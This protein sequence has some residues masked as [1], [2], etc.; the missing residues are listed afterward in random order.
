MAYNPGDSLCGCTL[1]RKCGTGAYGE[2]WLAE[3]PVGARVALKII[4]GGAVSERELNGLRNYKDCNHPNLLRIRHVEIADGEIRYTMDAADDLNRGVGEYKPDTLANR[5][6]KYGRM[7]GKEAAA[8]L[9]GLLAGLEELHRR[10]LVHRDIKPDNILWVNGRPTLADVGLV[11]ADGKGSLVGTP[12]FMSPKLMSGKGPADASDDFYAL[13]KVLYCALTGLPVGEYP[14]I[15]ASMTISADAALGR[16]YR[17][18]CRQ[19]VRSSAEF[20]KLLAGSAPAKMEKSA[21][22]P[23]RRWLVPCLFVL[24]VVPGLFGLRGGPAVQRA[25]EKAQAAELVAK[26]NEAKANLDKAQS[27]MKAEVEKFESGDADLRKEMQSRTVKLFLRVDLLPGDG[28]LAELLPDYET[29]AKQEILSLLMNGNRTPRLRPTAGVQARTVRT[30][31][32]LEHRLCGMF[33]A[34]YPD[35][36]RAKV[37]AR[38]TFWRN[39]PGTPA[40][41]QQKMLETD[42]VMQAVALDAMIRYKVNTILER[43]EFRSGEKRELG[44]LFELRQGLVEPIAGASFP[45]HLFAE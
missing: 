12:G 39:E 20:R 26:L 7:D 40:Q 10:G 29:M 43:G 14:S 3:D 8:M 1:L 2:V 42:P 21:R 28:K 13:G 37:K 45:S 34:A 25:G 19:P 11:A 44:E 17:E 35:F 30:P 36:D 27:D 22:I 38:Q 31:S 4:R 41:I 15:P 23:W 5:L 24:L 33:M 32:P 18:A 9:D 16:A 6:N